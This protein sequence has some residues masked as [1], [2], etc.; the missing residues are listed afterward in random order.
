MEIQLIPAIDLHRGK[1]VRLIGGSFEKEVVYGDDP[2]FFA[3]KFEVQGAQWLHVVDLDGALEGSC[4]NLEGLKKIRDNTHLNIE[5][6]GGLRSLEVVDKVL[7]MGIE[8]VIL[9]TKGLQED[10]LTQVLDRYS[11]KIAVSVDIHMGRVQTQGWTVQSNLPANE[12]IQNLR[13]LKVSC[14]I[15]TDISKDGTMSGPNLIGLQDVLGQTASMRVILSGGISTLD[16][17]RNVASIKSENF[18]GVIVGRA[19]YENRFSVADAIQIIR[20]TE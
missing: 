1:V 10:F 13:K 12:F 15:Y 5:F 19:L 2:I 18:Y 20:K 9:G 4:R 6:G 8:R 16:D 7:A 14:L 11:E 17:I 3:A